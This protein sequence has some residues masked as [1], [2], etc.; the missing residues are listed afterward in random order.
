MSRAGNSVKVWQN[1]PISNPK[2]DLHNINAYTKFGENSLMF[3]QVIIRKRKMEGWMYNWQTDGNMDVQREPI[4]PC[5]YCVVRYK[6]HV[7]HMIYIKYRALLSLKKKK[8]KKKE[9]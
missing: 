5:H 8:E 2:L 7:N 3:T 9:N 6:N 4:I 1:L